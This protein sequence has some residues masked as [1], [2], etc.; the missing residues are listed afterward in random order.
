M[1]KFEELEFEEKKEIINNKYN[2]FSHLSRLYLS[3]FVNFLS[4]AHCK[5]KLQ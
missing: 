3:V 5:M 1:K 2:I 4:F